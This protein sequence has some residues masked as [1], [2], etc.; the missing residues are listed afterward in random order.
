MYLFIEGID[1]S[2]TPMSLRG[3]RGR[4]ARFISDMMAA[5]TYNPTPI[6]GGAQMMIGGGL[7][8]PEE[9][10]EENMGMNGESALTHAQ[11]A[12]QAAAMMVGG[13]PTTVPANGSTPTPDSVNNENGSNGADEDQ[14][15]RA[16]EQHNLKMAVEFA[17]VNQAIIALSGQTPITIKPDSSTTECA[18]NSG[19][20]AAE[21][22]VSS[23]SSSVSSEQQNG[24]QASS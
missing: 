13:L 24:I 6:A 9:E 11:A 18:G 7:P 20:R 19:K 5:G 15:R 23:S 4:P 17:A 10:E 1:I 2:G 21:A 14:E 8:E 3:G 16:D 12:A 22:K